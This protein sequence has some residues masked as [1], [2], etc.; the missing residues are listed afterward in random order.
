[1]SLQAFKDKMAKDLYGITLTE[2]HSKKICVDCKS[3]MWMMEHLTEI[4]IKEWKISGLCPKCFLKNV[5][6][7]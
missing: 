4:D 6:V 1:M 2:A 7:E 3:E 5:G